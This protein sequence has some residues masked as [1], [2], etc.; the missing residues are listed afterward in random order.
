MAGSHTLGVMCNFALLTRNR[1]Q[2]SSWA[3]WFKPPL[4]VIAELAVTVAGGALFCVPSILPVAV[5]GEVIAIMGYNVVVGGMARVLQAYVPDSQ[6]GRHI[7]LGS[8]MRVTGMAV[9]RSCIVALDAQPSIGNLTMVP[10]YGATLGLGGTLTTF[11]LLLARRLVHIDEVLSAPSCR[12]RNQSNPS[13]NGVPGLNMGSPDSPRS[14]WRSSL[15]H[16]RNRNSSIF[17]LEKRMVSPRPN[18]TSKPS[19]DASLVSSLRS[20]QSSDSSYITNTA[21]L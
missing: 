4:D 19:L 1:D 16:Y 10:F 9:G 21:R 3:A 14:P 12:E 18:C 20:R 17:T 6:R 8:A 7:V 13:P 11:A 15:R 5:L 2:P